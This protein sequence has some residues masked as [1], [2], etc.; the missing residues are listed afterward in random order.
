MLVSS[1]IS[2]SYGDKKNEDKPKN[3]DLSSS[4]AR[5][6]FEPGSAAADMKIF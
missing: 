6:G 3:D 4:V 1:S 5:P 2:T